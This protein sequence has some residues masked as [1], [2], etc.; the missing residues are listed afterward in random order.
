[1]ADRDPIQP[2]HEAG[3][4]GDRGGAVVGPRRRRAVRARQRPGVAHLGDRDVPSPSRDQRGR[5]RGRHGPDR[6]GLAHRPL[7]PRV[8]P[9]HRPPASRD[10]HP[11]R[12]GPREVRHRRGVRDAGRRDRRGAADRARS[13]PD[14]PLARAAHALLPDPQG[15]PAEAEADHA[16]RVDRR[17]PARAVREPA[18]HREGGDRP[19]PRRHREA[20]PPRR[21]DRRPGLGLRPCERGPLPRAVRRRLR[22]DR[23]RAVHPRRAPGRVRARRA[24]VVGGEHEQGVRDPLLGPAAR[25]SERSRTHRRGSERMSQVFEPKQGPTEVRAAVETQVAEHDI[26]PWAEIEAREGPIAVGRMRLMGVY[27]DRQE[28]RFML[29]TRDP[30]RPAHRRPAGLHRRRRSATSATGGRA[31]PS[32]TGS[33]RSTTRQDIQI[34]LDRASTS[35]PRCG[36]ATTPPASRARRRAA[37]RCGTRPRARST[38]TTRAGTCA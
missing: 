12:G 2:I 1:M 14:V 27:D 33:A 31:T 35:C 32:P 19:R 11:V 13:E 8:H 18:Q 30:G 29:R 23:L 38:A 34:R 6:H 16:R 4:P 20:E 21:L 26:D 5:R 36:A 3:P 7:D 22:V 17:P 37:T 24:L 28:N 15:R 10:L 9:R 25:I